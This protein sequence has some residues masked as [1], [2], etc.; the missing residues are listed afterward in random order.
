MKPTDRVPAITAK[1]LVHIDPDSSKD[2]EQGISYSVRLDYSWPLTMNAQSLCVGDPDFDYA[3]VIEC[4][5][6]CLI[7]LNGEQQLKALWI[8]IQYKEGC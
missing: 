2:W 8:K 5:P 7:A 4:L 1:N 3:E 6:G